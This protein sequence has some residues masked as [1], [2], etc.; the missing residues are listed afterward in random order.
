MEPYRDDT[1]PMTQ[2]LNGLAP[3]L[4]HLGGLGLGDQWDLLPPIK[5]RPLKWDQIVQD[6]E[7]SPP[8]RGSDDY[9]VL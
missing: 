8:Q 2:P 4:C 5:V 9:V 7:C 6:W 1:E 3:S